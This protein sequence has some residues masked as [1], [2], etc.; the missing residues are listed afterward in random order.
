MSTRD[1]TKIDRTSG[2]LVKDPTSFAAAFPHG[3]TELGAVRAV[4]LEFMVGKVGLVL[5][6]EYGGVPVEGVDPADWAVLYCLLRQWDDTAIAAI[7]PNTATGAAS[8]SKVITGGAKG[9]VRAGALLTARAAKILFVPDDATNHRSIYLPRAIPV[10][11]GES[12]VAASVLR[13]SNVE[14]SW[15][16]LPDGSATRRSYQVGKLADLTL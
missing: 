13:E 9:A 4:E 1:V 8:G 16:G 7:W 14:V 3:G 15:I 2:R 6:E 10:I 5:A 12:R 11:V